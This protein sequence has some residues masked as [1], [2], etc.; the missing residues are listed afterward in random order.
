MRRPDAERIRGHGSS[1]EVGLYAC[2]L[3]PGSYRVGSNSCKVL[4]KEI[5][6][7]I[8]MAFGAFRAADLIS[9]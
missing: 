1:I 9:L 4:A 7:E 3:G 6:P 2:R 5:D 8:R